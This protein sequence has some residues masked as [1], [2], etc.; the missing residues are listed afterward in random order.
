MSAEDHAQELELKEWERNNKTRSDPVRHEPTD[1]GYGPEECIECGDDM[2]AVR[3]GYGYKLC[4]TC[5]QAR[6]PR[7][8]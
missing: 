6:E 5:Q 2:P 4:V 3:R 1:A 7:R 8:R